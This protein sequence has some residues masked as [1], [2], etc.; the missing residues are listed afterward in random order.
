[1]NSRSAPLEVST[2]NKFLKSKNGAC[3]VCIAIADRIADFAAGSGEKLDFSTVNAIATNFFDT[4][5]TYIGTAAF[6]GLGQLRFSG[7]T[8]YGNTS[9]DLTADFR[10]ALTGVTSLTVADLVL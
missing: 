5:F 7:G 9:G 2:I 8:L 3:R 10:V 1:M 6:T 4:A